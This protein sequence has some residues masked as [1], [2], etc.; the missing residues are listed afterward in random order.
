MSIKCSS[1][2]RRYKL[3]LWL[4]VSDEKK[5]KDRGLFF[6]GEVEES[7]FRQLEFSDGLHKQMRERIKS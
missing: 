3:A 2:F 5:R 7:S 4:H 6:L 1:L